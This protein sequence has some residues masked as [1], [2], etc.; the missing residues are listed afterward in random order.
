MTNPVVLRRG[1]FFWCSGGHG[2]R[3]GL[4]CVWRDEGLHER[5][6]QAPVATFSF[7][8]G[9]S[10]Q[11]H[12][13]F[14]DV[15]AGGGEQAL[16][17]DA[18]EAAHA[19]I[20]VAVQLLGIGE[21]AFHRLLAPCIQF[22]APVGQT[23]GVNVVL[24]VLPDVAGHHLG[25]VG[26]GGARC[27]QRASPALGRVALVM[28]IAVAVGGG[29]GQDLAG[30]T[31]IGVKRAVIG[32]V[33]LAQETVAVGGAAI[34]DHAFDPAVLQSLADAGG[35]IAGI[36][37]DG[38]D[39]EAEALALAVEAAQIGNAVMDVTGSDEAVGDDGVLAVHAAVI[40]V[41]EALGLTV[42]HHV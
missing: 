5:R 41:E 12:S 31:A 28:A 29:I 3:P 8:G 15:L 33:A 2:A 16:L 36:Q 19:G 37:S 42:T 23:V 38:A 30:G 25:G 32:E 13:D 4:G 6:N 39:I 20:A 1:L 17:L 22:L 11:D 7:S 34:A 9:V 18:I 24:G 35:G 40:E 10:R 21:A 27:Q 14:L 26:A